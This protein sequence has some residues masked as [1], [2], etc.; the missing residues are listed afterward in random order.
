MPF[1]GAHPA[2]FLPFLRSGMVSAT[3]LIAGSIAPDFEYFLRMHTGN[4]ISHDWPGVFLFDLPVGLGIALL[5]H[6]VIRQPLLE[7]LPSFLQRRF[8]KVWTLD[9]RGYLKEHP[10]QF[11]LC[12]LTGILSHIGWDIITH[13]SRFIQGLAFYQETYLTIGK[14]KYPLFYVLQQISTF[15]GFSLVIL[16]VMLMPADRSTLSYSSDRRFWPILVSIALALFLIRFLLTGW[17]FDLGN[18]VVSVISSLMAGL[19]I[20]S[21][22]T[23]RRAA[24]LRRMYGVEGQKA[25]DIR[26]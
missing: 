9:F 21:F 17:K 5:F 12:L 8:H 19:M 4:T 7:N 2:I 16:Y 18:V 14:T 26:K 22:L 10:V 15:I 25:A 11:F 24:G 6:Q 13:N 23:R 1:T 3:G 20:S